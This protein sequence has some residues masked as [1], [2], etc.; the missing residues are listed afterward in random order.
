MHFRKSTGKTNV[1]S[2]NHVGPDTCARVNPSER[3]FTKIPIWVFVKIPNLLKN[4]HKRYCIL[5]P[6]YTYC[7]SKCQFFKIGT[8]MA[9]CK[10]QCR[11]Q[12]S[13]RSVYKLVCFSFRIKLQQRCPHLSTHPCVPHGRPI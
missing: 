3:I 8:E 10:V 6:L 2:L 5:I 7:L 12:Y 13:I 9:P 4:G 1:A 11:V